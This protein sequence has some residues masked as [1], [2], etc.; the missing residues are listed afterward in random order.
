MRASESELRYPLGELEPT[1]GKTL[2]IAPAPD[3]DW[4]GDVRWIRMRLPFALNHINLWLMRDVLDTPE[5]KVHGWTAVDCCIYSDEAKAQWE[6]L[7]TFELDGLPLLRVIVTH[8]HPDHIGLADWLCKRWSTP[9]RPCRLWMS[10]TDHH[11]ARV[12]SAGSSGFG[13]FAAANFF[14]SHGMK[15]FD[16]IQ[17]IRERADYYRTLVPSVPLQYRRIMDGEVLRIGGRAWQCIVGLGHA[18]EHIA[19]YCEEL[20]LLIGGDMMLPRIST[21]VSVYE[22]EPEANPLPQFLSSI[23]KFNALP[24]DTLTL[25]SHG[26]PFYGLHQRVQQLLDHHRDRLA[27]VIQACTERPCSAADIVPVLFTRSLNSHQLSFAM[28]EA[29]AHLHAL[30][31]DEKLSRRLDRDGVFRFSAPPGTP[32]MIPARSRF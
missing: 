2:P 29:I 16:S 8:M 27:E 19:L 30:W 15:D 25:P 26:R 7:F 12:G 13:G 32:P 9:K 3:G 24:E 18:P 1:R 31:F 23:K 10:G 21:N 14:S 5:G 11:L 22:M 17:K 4:L 20:R 28:G 6:E